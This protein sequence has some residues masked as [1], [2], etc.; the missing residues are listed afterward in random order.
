MSLTGR[1]GAVLAVLL[2]LQGCAVELFK[3]P[4]AHS[5]AVS[6]AITY[7]IAGHNG[8][9]ASFRIAKREPI[10]VSSQGWRLCSAEELAGFTP[11]DLQLLCRPAY[12]S[13]DPQCRNTQGCVA[14]Q[15]DPSGWS[16]PEMHAVVVQA[17]HNPCRFIPQAGIPDE[18]W[19]GFFHSKNLNR[20]WLNCDSGRLPYRKVV[21]QAGADEH[22][23]EID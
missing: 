15:L 20:A 5:G 13:G 12:S 6:D 3:N 19:A 1:L 17:L 14:L 22:D 21:I 16:D 10:P 23:I 2:L 4:N 11:R 18:H 8:N 9:T 7:A